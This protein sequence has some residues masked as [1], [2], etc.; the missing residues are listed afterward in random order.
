[1]LS[2]EK[3]IV[4]W[5]KSKLTVLEVDSPMEK[6][7]WFDNYWSW[8]ERLVKKLRKSEFKLA[9]IVLLIATIVW[10]I[11][12]YYTLQGYHKYC[13]WFDEQPWSEWT[14]RRPWWEWNG[15]PYIIITGIF[16]FLAWFVFFWHLFTEKVY[17]HFKHRLSERKKTLLSYALFIL[18]VLTPIIFFW[19][20]LPN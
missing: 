1:L 13:E 14:L 16:L 3:R 9:F 12:F 17:P 10:G 15:M 4:E 2:S 20:A 6:V 8:L 18:L 11:A 5:F 7:T 19:I